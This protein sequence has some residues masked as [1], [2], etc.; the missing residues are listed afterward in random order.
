MPAKMAPTRLPDVA[1]SASKIQLERL[2][3]VYFEHVDLSKFEKFAEDF[4][5]VEAWRDKDTI[6]YRGYGQDQYCYVAR[7]AKGDKPN[8]QGPA[9]VAQDAAEFDKAVA[10]EGAVV[11][12][13]SPFPGGG[14]MVTLKTPAGFFLRV[15]HGQEDREN[16][17]EIP[18]AQVEH[19]GPLNGSKDKHRYG[20][21]Q[22]D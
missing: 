16:T 18:T 4:G 17:P 6:L 11:S 19:L 15:V 3:H 12:D 8:F 7:Q 1:N 22:F 21:S 2:S 14:K 10:I 13:L 5:L 9:F 20:K